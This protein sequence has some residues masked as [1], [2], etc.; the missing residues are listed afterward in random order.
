MGRWTNNN[1]IG[2]AV[3]INALSATK[4]LWLEHPKPPRWASFGFCLTNWM[5]EKYNVWIPSSEKK[6][7]LQPRLQNRGPGNISARLKIEALCEQIYI[8]DKQWLRIPLEHNWVESPINIIYLRE[9]KS[10]CI[11][12]LP[13]IW[14]ASKRQ[15]CAKHHSEIDLESAWRLGIVPPKLSMLATVECYN[16][17]FLRQ[18]C[19]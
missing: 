12:E 2:E 15:W 18:L 11:F 8:R 7:H 10:A 13:G 19:K 1:V 4:V 6:R 14:Y 3:D 5:D 17:F 9:R 16:N